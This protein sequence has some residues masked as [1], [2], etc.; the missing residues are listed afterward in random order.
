MTDDSWAWEL[1]LAVFR[2]NRCLHSTQINITSHAAV[3]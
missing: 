1:R 2:L 3:H